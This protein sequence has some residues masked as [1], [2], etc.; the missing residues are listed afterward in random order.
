MC[1]AKLFS[2]RALLALLKRKNVFFDVDI[3]VEKKSKR[4]LAWSELSS[5]TS[6][7]HNSFPKHF[8]VLFLHVKRKV[9]ERKALRIQ[10]AHLRNAAR[11]LLSPS[12]CFQ[13]STNLDKDFCRN[14]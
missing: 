5:T 13:L 12:Q 9:F 11:A 10:V 4:G 7:R 1:R 8:V 14:L 2:A 6:T 3:A